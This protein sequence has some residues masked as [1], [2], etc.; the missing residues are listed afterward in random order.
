VDGAPARPQDLRDLAV[1]A[2]ARMLQRRDA[3]AV[4]DRHVRSRVDQRSHDLLVRGPAVTEDDRLEQ[5][6]P[7]Q[8]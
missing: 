3:V 5:R 4:G 6:G 7:P 8:P 2:L 1:A